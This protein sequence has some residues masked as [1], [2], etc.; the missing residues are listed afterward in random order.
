MEHDTSGAGGGANL[1]HPVLTSA[2]Q[3]SPPLL[4]AV[5]ISTESIEQVAHLKSL[6][7]GAAQVWSYSDNL[8]ESKWRNSMPQRLAL[9]GFRFAVLC[10]MSSGLLAVVSRAQDVPVAAI[11]KEDSSFKFAVKSSIPVSGTF[12]KWDAT[13]TFTSPDVTTAVLDIRIQAD[14]VNTGSGLKDK[15]MKG[16][17]YFDVKHDPLITFHSTKI[18]QTGPVSFDVDGDFTIH[19]VTKSEKLTLVLT[20]KDKEEAE[21]KG[22]MFFDRKDYGMDKNIPFVTVADRIEVIDD[23]KVKK[24]SGPPLVFRQGLPGVIKQ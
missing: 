1:H 16:K 15:T 5:I 2:S 3:L 12:D 22:T 9:D 6:P 24:V 13:I 4:S 11:S 17:D 21:V 14:S 18:T 23:L 10:I 7:A 19:G 20:V 8:A